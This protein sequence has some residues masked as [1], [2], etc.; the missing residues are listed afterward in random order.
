MPVKDKLRK[1]KKALPSQELL[2]II[3]KFDFVEYIH[4]EITKDTDL[5]DEI[6][7]TYENKTVTTTILN[8]A[9]TV[10]PNL[11]TGLVTELLNHGAEIRFLYGLENNRA[12]NNINSLLDALIKYRI[13][14]EIKGNEIN[15]FVDDYIRVNNPPEFIKQML[16]EYKDCEILDQ[17]DLRDVL[18]E[19]KQ[20]TFVS[21]EISNVLDQFQDRLILNEEEVP[22]SKKLGS[23][24]FGTV[25]LVAFDKEPENP[26]IKQICKY[27]TD[28]KYKVAMKIIS[29][30]KMD[31]KAKEDFRNE[32]ITANVLSGPYRLDPKKCPYNYQVDAIVG[33]KQVIFARFEEKGEALEYL[34]KEVINPA[35]KPNFALLSAGII[36]DIYAGMSAMH[37]IQ[38]SKGNIGIIHNDI[39]LRNVL[40]GDAIKD[41]DNKTVL[42]YRAKLSDFGLSKHLEAD[43]T[44]EEKSDTGPLYWMHEERS[45]DPRIVSVASDLFAFRMSIIETIVAASGKLSLKDYFQIAPLVAATEVRDHGAINRLKEKYIP[46]IEKD[47]NLNQNII[48][49][50]FRDYLLAQPNAKPSKAEIDNDKKILNDAFTKFFILS[51]NAELKNVSQP[52]KLLLLIKQL[53]VNIPPLKNLDATEKDIYQLCMKLAK[54]NKM[55]ESD[56]KSLSDKINSF[57]KQK[58]NSTVIPEMETP[59]EQPPSTPI[60]QPSLIT[61]SEIKPIIEM[62]KKYNE[63]TFF[64]DKNKINMGIAFGYLLKLKD[65]FNSFRN[66]TPSNEIS[67]DDRVEL[68]RLENL[69][70]TSGIPKEWEKIS[71]RDKEFRAITEFSGLLENRQ[72]IPPQEKLKMFI[73]NL[74]ALIK[75]VN[76][77]NINKEIFQ[78]NFQDIKRILK[79]E[80]LKV[81]LAIVALQQPNEVLAIN[82]EQAKK[83]LAYKEEK[84]DS[85]DK[86]KNYPE[87]KL[88]TYIEKNGAK[89][90]DNLDNTHMEALSIMASAIKKSKLANKPDLYSALIK[91]LNSPINIASILSTI[92]HLNKDFKASKASIASTLRNMLQM[93]INSISNET[94]DEV[95]RHIPDLSKLN[96]DDAIIDLVESSM[97]TDKSVLDYAERIAKQQEQ[98]KLARRELS[99]E[100]K[101]KILFDKVINE[102]IQTETTFL[103]NMAILARQ[104]NK[105]VQPDNHSIDGNQKSRLKQLLSSIPFEEISKMSS[106][107]FKT[108]NQLNEA[109]QSNSYIKVIDEL[110][111]YFQQMNFGLFSSCAI[112]HANLLQILSGSDKNDPLKKILEILVID[113]NLKIDAFT[114]MPVQRIPRYELLL[115]DLIKHI[116]EEQPQVDAEK[117]LKETIKPAAEQMNNFMSGFDIKNEMIKFNELCKKPTLSSRV[118]KIVA[119]IN[120]ILRDDNNVNKANLQDLIMKIGDKPKYKELRDQLNRLVTIFTPKKQD[121]AVTKTTQQ[122]AQKK[123]VPPQQMV[124]EPSQHKSLVD[125]ATIIKTKHDDLVKLTQQQSPNIETLR[126]TAYDLL[127]SFKKYQLLATSY[128]R[129]SQGK[130]VD[131]RNE[132][133]FI[134]SDKCQQRYVPNEDTVGKDV[135][136]IINTL[137]TKANDI[138]KQSAD[139]NQASADATDSLAKLVETGK[140]MLKQME[141][142]T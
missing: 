128:S 93:E 31:N 91:K 116:P 41:A 30:D 138:Y 104:L 130:E 105:L 102:F 43:G 4:P 66:R 3:N 74:T 13:P 118:K 83:I 42:G 135:E 90:F 48:F 68:A 140:E 122:T 84:L 52:D 55:T 15:Q 67:N 37:Q 11:E 134:L 38:N 89:S 95:K 86:L 123:A 75:N 28:K 60:E 14:T 32:Q 112:N 58:P 18:N 9:V 72:A 125:L 99:T 121:E 10:D 115:R 8:L 6:N 2:D 87:K 21:P 70:K 76:D 127:K 82:L 136:E 20:V 34:Q 16:L 103:D 85:P 57:D 129:N 80:N 94:S 56:I 64:T 97:R 96:D 45:R 124:L 33:G 50:S 100:E 36:R 133:N 23:G 5:N 81:I 131:V 25:N 101:N 19:I 59:I 141:Q 110:K 26:N 113:K 40:V 53:F 142:L 69:L 111:K 44:Y 114:I 117:L 126:Q 63:L 35:N 73:A 27:D 109:M 92:K 88:L 1:R 17:N 51:L 71:N 132:A 62:F 46:D 39:A 61:S 139:A 119:E 7:F 78:T 79:T 54:A 49:K 65:A 108:K 106:I 137:C 12:N 24:A 120:T 47:T 29:P 22:I 98:Q 77:P 107:L